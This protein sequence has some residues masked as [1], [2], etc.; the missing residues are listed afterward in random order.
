MT[1]LNQKCN[2]QCIQTTFHGE[3]HLFLTALGFPTK[4][5]L[6]KAINKDNLAT[7]SVLVVQAINKL[8]HEFNKIQKGHMK[9]Q[10]QN[11]R[12]MNITVNENNKEDLQPPTPSKKHEDV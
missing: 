1:D 10:H 6:T 4:A 5:T 3:G 11:V 12:S 7:F 9:Q 8:F 2:S